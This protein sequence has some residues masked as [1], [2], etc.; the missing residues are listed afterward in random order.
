MNG[1]NDSKIFEARYFRRLLLSVGLLLAVG[2]L[3]TILWLSIKVW[4]AG[5]A[6]VLLAVFFRA[7]ANW[8]TRVTHLRGTW[9]LVVVLVGLLGL[10]TL[11]GWLVAPRLSEQFT[12]LTQRLPALTEKLHQRFTESGW[13]RYLPQQMPSASDLSSSAGKLASQ[14]TSFFKLSTEAVAIFFVIVFLG[15]YLAAAPQ[16]YIQGLIQMFPPTKRERVRDI[17]DQVGVTLGHWLLG[18]MISMTVVG[19]LIAVGLILLDVPLGLALGVLAGLLNFIPII[20]AWVSAVPAVFLAFTVSPLHSLYVIFLY[21]VVNAGIESHLLIPLIQR[22]AIHLPPA[23]AVV[24]LFLMSELFGFFGVLL[25]IP[26]A[27]TLLVLIKTIYLQD[28]LGDRR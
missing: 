14:A 25:A 23:L 5:F 19:T 1:E 20:G 11:G 17:L 8:V 21:L 2:L 27:A 22:Y 26:M 28:V 24:A 6:G 10:A 15:I 4:L 16:V 3:V 9:A 13:S 18:Q 7:L 12:E